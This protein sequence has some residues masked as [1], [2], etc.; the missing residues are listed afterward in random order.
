[1]RPSPPIFLWSMNVDKLRAAAKAL[2][3][4]DRAAITEKDDLI[5]AIRQRL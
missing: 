4:P 5:A 1:M 2:D 3:V